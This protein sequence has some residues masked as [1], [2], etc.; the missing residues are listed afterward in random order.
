MKTLSFLAL[1]LL[2]ITPALAQ[3]IDAV[4]DRMAQRQGQMVSLKK[5]GLIGENNQGYLSE[6]G[7]LNGAQRAALQA[8][9]ADR[10]VVYS[11]I[12]KRTGADPSFVGRERAQDI[13]QKSAS[14]IWLQNEAGQWFKK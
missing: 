9:N 13:R 1:A 2:L 3:D 4:R 11:T 7:A 10:R 14:G 12:A 8:E 6:R 5:A